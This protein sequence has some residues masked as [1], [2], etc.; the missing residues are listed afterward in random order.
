MRIIIAGTTQYIAFH[1]QA[2]FMLNLAEGLA[3]RGHNVLA[4]V[5]SE[6]GDGYR[7]E[8]NG[9]QIEALPSISLKLIHPDV[10]LSL[11]SDRIIR[12]V[13]KNFHP[14]IVHIQDHYPMCRTASLAA[15]KFK[16][17]R[18]GTNHFM[19]ENLAPYI[20][21]VSKIT[22]VYNWVLWTWMK[23]V[24]NQLDLVASP[25]QTAANILRRQHLKP[26]VTPIS[27]GVDVNLFHLDPN[28]DRPAM[29]ARYGLDPKQK[30][31]FFV[32]RVD[33]EKR[34]DVILRALHRI[35]RE[36]IQFVITG[37]G[38]AID[39]LK[40]LASEL[41]LG[42]KVH[43]T[44]FIPNADLPAI[45]NSIDIFT[46][47]SE[48]ELLSIA[49]LE[50]MAC[51]RPVL[52]ADAVALPELVSNGQNGYL[53]RPGDE[54]DAACRMV[55]MADNKEQWQEMGRNSLERAQKHSLENIIT[56]YEK[57]YETALAGHTD[58]SSL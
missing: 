6:K 51:A 9:V 50:A 22:P 33:K 40:T 15:K 45:L 49:T 56:K 44:G 16:V 35:N 1:G 18:V 54:A 12:R 30:L 23:E 13:I 29:C 37:N 20:P 34:L 17:K 27:C 4:L 43:F 8:L 26:S 42:P 10:Y 38:A 31:F 36:D 3:R 2:I 46:M 32:G 11:F 24:Y 21:V 19:P 25:S 48:A 53:F 39:G 47:P 52:A 41:N 57:F 14:D 28:V 5:N 58:E 7:A 55:Q